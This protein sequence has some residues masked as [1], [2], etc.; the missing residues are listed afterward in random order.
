MAKT[1]SSKTKDSSA[2][3]VLRMAVDDVGE[4]LLVPV[5]QG[6]VEHEGL[7]LGLRFEQSLLAG[8][9][10]SAR[11]LSQGGDEWQVLDGR[12]ADLGGARLARPGEGSPCAVLRPKKQ[13]SGIPEGG[14]LLVPMGLEMGFTL[15]PRGSGFAV[16]DLDQPVAVFLEP[17]GLV[18]GCK[19]GVRCSRGQGDFD[20]S[21]PKRNI[22]W[23]GDE[24]V[25]IWCQARPGAPLFINLQEGPGEIGLPF[26]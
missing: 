15:G 2:S 24:T 12:N 14:I 3:R 26:D 9:V 18:V 1:P 8:P 4:F 19:G 10:W 16:A 7:G 20:G 23:P 25:T 11:R 5:P 13:T 21:L 22:A 17:D 6:G